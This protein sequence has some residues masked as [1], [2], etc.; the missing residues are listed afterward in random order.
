MLYR[1]LCVKCQ[2]TLSGEWFEPIHGW[3]CSW[4]SDHNEP[5]EALDEKET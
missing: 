5:V 4:C 1:M 2:E 3:I